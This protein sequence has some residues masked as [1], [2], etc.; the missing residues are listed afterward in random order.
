MY[1]PHP[2]T[3]SRPPSPGS[4]A[5]RLFGCALAFIMVGACSE[6]VGSPPST[7]DASAQTDDPSSNNAASNNAPSPNNEPPSSVVTGRVLDVQGE[8]LGAAHVQL[9]GPLDG[10][11]EQGPNLCQTADIFEDGT[12]VL[13]TER[14][15][16]FKLGVSHTDSD[17]RKFSGAALPVELSSGSM[18]SIGDIWLPE[19]EALH[20]VDDGQTQATIEFDGIE[21]HLNPADIDWNFREPQLGVAEVAREHWPTEETADGA[22]VVAVWAWAPYGA[23]ARDSTFTVKM[24]DV[25][26]LRPDARLG[27]FTVSKETGRIKGV[28]SAH[29]ASDGQIESGPSGFEQLTWLMLAVEED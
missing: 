29:V 23:F 18:V 27:L 20:S 22:R 13:E 4:A 19:V 28:G 24:A 7:D 11:P 26:G 3:T 2:K 16:R 9:C 12:F 15:G 1:P 25:F 10:R 14:W 5:L 21:L 6:P 17:A 8:T